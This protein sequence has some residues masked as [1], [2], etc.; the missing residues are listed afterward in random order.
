M[1][2]YISAKILFTIKKVELIGKK[3]FAAAVLDLNYKVFV[4]Y[5]ATLNISYNIGDKVHLS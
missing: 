3:E 4:V 2:S 5:I 1:K